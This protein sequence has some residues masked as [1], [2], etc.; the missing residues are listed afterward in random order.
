MK[1]NITNNVINTWVT[2]EKGTGLSINVTI[3]PKA[4]NEWKGGTVTVKFHDP[5]HSTV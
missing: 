4:Q 5:D 3:Y 1:I 2:A